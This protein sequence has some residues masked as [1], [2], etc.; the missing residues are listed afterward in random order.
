[1]KRILR[2]IEFI[3]MVL[4]TCIDKAVGVIV[5]RERVIIMLGIFG[6]GKKKINQNHY[7]DEDIWTK[8]AKS[9]E[10][11]IPKG[12][13]VFGELIG[14]TSNGKPIQNNYTYDVPKGKAKIYIY[15][16]VIINSDGVLCDLSWDAVRE[17][18]NSIG[19]AHVPEL[20]QVSIELLTMRRHNDSTDKDFTMLD[21]FMDVNFG[22]LTYLTDNPVPLAADSPCD[23]GVVVRIEGI[24]PQLY[25]VKAPMFL[26]HE[27]K[28]LD[29]G[30]PDIESES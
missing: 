7:Y 3:F 6:L 28:E 15:R 12:Y 5:V 29:K 17:F 2:Y 1:M 21:N 8:T 13:I 22:T 19:V 26:A 20:I 23:E 25:K 10:G 9:L 4:E 11:L 27:T 18:C 30:V 16:V 24:N 14:W